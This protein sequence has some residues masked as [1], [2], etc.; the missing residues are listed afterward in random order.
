MLNKLVTDSELN[1]ELLACLQRPRTFDSNQWYNEILL[2]IETDA[3]AN[4]EIRI[5][6]G[7]S[8]ITIP[9]LPSEAQDIMIPTTYWSWGDVTTIKLFKNLGLV[10]KIEITFPE[11]LEG[12]LGMLNPDEN[13]PT[14]FTM[15]SSQNDPTDL[16]NEISNVRSDLPY[17]QD[18]SVNTPL[19]KI[20]L[21]QT[22]IGEG[23]Q[24]DAGTLW[25]VYE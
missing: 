4:Q 24:L 11:T 3:T 9:L 15:I 10:G 18:G 2:L 7:V 19:E 25:L 5:E 8:G 23:V 22:D 20:V 13:D 12:C 16:A 14:K 6:T 17:I 21:S 1:V